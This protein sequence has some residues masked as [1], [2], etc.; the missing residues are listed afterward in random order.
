MVSNGEKPPAKGKY[1]D[2]H[3]E[4][5]LHELDQ[6]VRALEFA[7]LEEGDE[8][9]ENR[10]INISRQI[11]TIKLNIYTVIDRYGSDYE[12]PE[13]SIEMTT[14]VIDLIKN[15]KRKEILDAL[16]RHVKDMQEALEGAG[17]QLTSPSEPALRAPPLSS[18]R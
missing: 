11:R 15:I 8:K 7:R 12:N 1:I 9:Y 13:R 4:S 17:Y 16:H 5:L 14:K 6:E 18:F 2:V 3:Y 10:V